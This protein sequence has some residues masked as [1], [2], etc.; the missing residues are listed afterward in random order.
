MNVVSFIH[1][2]RTFLPC[3]GVGRHM[4]GVL[5]RLATKP[6]VRLQ[7]LFSAQWLGSDRLL[8]ANCPLR[9]LPATTFPMGENSTERLWKLLG[10]P[11]MDDFVVK[12]TDWVY[13][14][15]D[16]RFPIRR[17][18]VAVTIHD[19][20]A[21]EQDLP[22]STS[23][24]HRRFRWKWAW[25]I[26][27]TIRE[28]RIVFTV[29]EFSRRR[30]VDLLGAP[31]DKIIVV[32]NGV[33]RVYLDHALDRNRHETA[34]PRVAIVGGLREKKGASWTL[35]VARH[36]KDQLPEARFLVIG[37]SE[38]RWQAEAAAIG[39]FEF[40]GW[41][42]DDQLPGLLANAFALLFLSP[43]EGFGIPAL[44]AMAV[45]TPPI[46]ADRASLPEVVAGHG[47]VVNPEAPADIAALLAGLADGS[48]H[49]DADAGRRWAASHT[50]DVV[51]DRVHQALERHR[52]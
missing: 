8:P 40:H 11:R 6:D 24:A 2:Q 49:Y 33:D 51:A 14:P 36:L 44:E 17:C 52:G 37:P 41:A 42:D 34:H 3:S 39:T 50:W 28:S 31:E 12:D 47:F 22:W 32:G 26:G 4:N 35:S 38:A 10:R 7:L 45:G 25:W 16:T 30:M 43:Y 21:F 20:Q 9:S 46:V 5:P 19:I 13:C 27:K 15:M 18:P 1:P 29:S 48:E 23:M